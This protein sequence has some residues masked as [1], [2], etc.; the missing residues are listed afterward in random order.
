MAGGRPAAPSSV[1]KDLDGPIGKRSHPHHPFLT[2]CLLVDVGSSR[3]LAG[4][5]VRV[6]SVGE[7]GPKGWRASSVAVQ[8]PPPPTPRGRENKLIQRKGKRA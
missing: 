6:R 1:T 3:A 7:R 2:V 8:P 4:V 5:E